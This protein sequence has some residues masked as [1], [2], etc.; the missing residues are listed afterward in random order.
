MT[1]TLSRCYAVSG[2]TIPVRASERVCR[3]VLS[4][5]P[6]GRRQSGWFGVIAVGWALAVAGCGGSSSKPDGSS[7]PYGP[8]SS[9]AAMS[10]CMRANGVSGFPDPREGRNGGGVGFPGG[11]FVTGSDSMVAMGIPFSGPALLSGGAGLHGVSPAGRPAA[12]GVRE[13][14]GGGDRQCPVPAQARR[15][16]LPRPDVLRRPARFRAWRDQPPI[17]GVHAGRGGVR[18]HQRGRAARQRGAIDRVADGPR[19]SSALVG[20]LH[21]ATTATTSRRVSPALV[22]VTAVVLITA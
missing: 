19:T 18:R 13:P 10:R 16:Q 21:R 4:T 12:G 14:A 3:A 7:D 20:H 15:A 1:T 8:A 5:E 11:L 22:A 9:P 6:T 17:T 2:T